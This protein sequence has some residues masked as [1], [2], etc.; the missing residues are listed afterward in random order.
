MEKT[1]PKEVKLVESNIPDLYRMFGAAFDLDAVQN[2][3]VNG[4]YYAINEQN[5]TGNKV[6][7]GAWGLGNILVEIEAPDLAW[8]RKVGTNAAQKISP[9]AG[10]IKKVEASPVRP[11]SLSYFDK[12]IYDFTPSF[13]PK[14]IE[15]NLYLR[16]YDKN[17]L[18]PKEKQEL[19]SS[20]DQK[21]F[22]SLSYH[23]VINNREYRA[24]FWRFE[25]KEDPAILARDGMVAENKLISQTK[26]Y[27]E[28]LQELYRFL[29][30]YKITDYETN[31]ASEV[32][33]KIKTGIV[34]PERTVYYELRDHFGVP[35]YSYLTRAKDQA[36][37][38][39]LKFHFGNLYGH[40]SGPD[41][42][43]L[44]ELRDAIL[45]NIKA[46][47]AVVSKKEMKA[48]PPAEKVS[49]TAS[50]LPSALGD[51]WHVA[52]LPATNQ[53]PACIMAQTQP[54]ALV[55]FAI[56]KS[57]PDA[58]LVAGN[59]SG[60]T[61]QVEADAKGMA[62]ALFY[63]SGGRL[64]Q[65][66]KYEVKCSV[67]E[68]KDAVTIHVGLGLAFHR[69]KAI[70]GAYG[71]R[72]PFTLSLVSRHFPKLNLGVYFS[73][74]SRKVW[75]GRTLGIKLSLEWVNKPGNLPPDKAFQGITKIT[76]VRQGAGDTNVLTVLSYTSGEETVYNITKYAYPAVKMMSEGFHSYRIVGELLLTDQD[77][78]DLGRIDEQL[79]Q[80][81]ALAIISKES[82]EHFLVS[83]VSSLEAQT[84]D[85]FLM[86]E[87]L[88]KV[89]V[90]GKFVDEF[91]TVL[92]LLAK[93]GKSDYEGLLYD[94]NNYLG[95]KW[96]DHLE[97]PEVFRKLTPR[98]QKAVKFA[99]TAFD[100]AQ[101][102]KSKKEYSDQK[103]KGNANLLPSVEYNTDLN[104][105]ELSPEL[106]GPSLL[107]FE[108][109]EKAIQK[110]EEEK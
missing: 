107:D 97:T 56:A 22:G 80:S 14:V 43:M 63:Y 20:V 62:K 40:L 7:R 105:L 18:L 75:D 49:L 84:P 36:G 91:L 64:D 28:V 96:L 69:I 1:Y 88:K 81:D 39:H 9:D 109:A 5:F 92:G 61:V 99:K 21:H 31:I 55:T 83:L 98:Q 53:L 30:E 100:G 70:K 16:Q 93:L 85:Q 27:R 51:E 37:N 108:E 86:L 50:A 33:E 26:A 77:G 102:V 42:A 46:S 34:V 47:Q 60:T 12:P 76:P 44:K 90:Y 58:Y 65:P 2:S 59:A 106:I 17:A 82:P 66:R 72:H 78:K 73:S 71:D 89:P 68:E 11:T 67:G 35:E 41:M 13:V 87:F 4:I 24:E 74:A 54:R 10:A 95:G 104:T 32:V 3:D 38:A 25:E 29:C 45:G 48:R 101:K 57:P 110:M 79:V 23:F 94:L 19:A 52:Y 8:V 6:F 15:D 103:I